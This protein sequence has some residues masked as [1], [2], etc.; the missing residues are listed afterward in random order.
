VKLRDHMLAAGAGK[1]IDMPTLM[2]GISQGIAL[3]RG[4]PW[5]AELWWQELDDITRANAEKLAR[6]TV[7]TWPVEGA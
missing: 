6:V 7:E 5:W 3:A 4:Y 1:P 2:A